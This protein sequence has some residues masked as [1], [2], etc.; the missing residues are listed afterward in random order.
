MRARMLV[1]DIRRFGHDVRIIS[2]CFD[3][4]CPHSVCKNCMHAIVRAT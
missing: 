4:M 2:R 1:F 3:R